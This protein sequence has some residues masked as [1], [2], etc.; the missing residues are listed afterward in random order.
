M[1]PIPYDI[2]YLFAIARQESVRKAG[3]DL[4]EKTERVT[5]S[6]PE[7]EMPEKSGADIPGEDD[8]IEE[9]VDGNSMRDSTVSIGQW[10][11]FRRSNLRSSLPANWVG[12]VSYAEMQRP[13]SS[14]LSGSI[15]Q[16]PSDMNPRLRSSLHRSR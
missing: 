2:C 5:D 15:S 1:L 11:S 16:R 4:V 3:E 13:R 8:F 9:P 10:P 14:V 6:E 12:D 7:I